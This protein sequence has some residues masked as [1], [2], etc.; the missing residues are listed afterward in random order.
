M[1]ELP[2]LEM[3]ISYACNLRCAGCTHYSNYGIGGYVDFEKG[4][5]WLSAWRKRLQPREFS[6]LGGEPM[7]NPRVSDYIRLIAE[8]WPASNRWFITNG[9]FLDRRHDL[10]CAL[11]ESNTQLVVSL[12]SNSPKYRAKVQAQLVRLAHSRYA[13]RVKAHIRD[14]VLFY[15]TYRRSREEMRPFNDGNPRQSWLLCHNRE[16][17]TIHLGRLWKCPPIAFLGLV[18]GKFGLAG[19]EEW[20]PYLAYK[21]IAPEATDEE[22]GL[23]LRREEEDICRM[24]PSTPKFFEALPDL[25]FVV[26]SYKENHCLD[27]V[28]RPE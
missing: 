20:K 22:L 18:T 25:D 17:R 12:H 11:A 16:C 27:S 4:C 28:G 10:M 24:C 1:F 23:F 5:E 8:L 13:D 15:R 2:S 26:R 6:L 7:L 14:S 9:F 19:V 21:G 3:D